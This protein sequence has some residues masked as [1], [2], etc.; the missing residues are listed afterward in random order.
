LQKVR[1]GIA[2]TILLQPE[3]A[4]VEQRPRILLGQP[5]LPGNGLLVGRGGFVVTA[6]PGIGE[7]QVVL[8]LDVPRL[9][10]EALLEGLDGLLEPVLVVLGPAEVVPGLGVVR[11]RGR[12]PGQQPVRS[13]VVP[14]ERLVERGDLQVEC[15]GLTVAGARRVMPERF[16]G[17]GS[18]GLRMCAAFPELRRPLLDLAEEDVGEEEMAV[19]RRGLRLHQAAQA[20]LRLI[21]SAL[22]QQ[23][24]RRG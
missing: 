10:L 19:R 17:Q 24:P 8:R 14:Q 11:V 7:P 9:Q 2:R 23:R 15:I 13:G 1:E 18:R 21:Q 12:G 3:R 20:L 4:Q 16:A 22:V 6:E 5:R